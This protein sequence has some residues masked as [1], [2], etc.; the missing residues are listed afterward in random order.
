MKTK[1]KG[2]AGIVALVAVIVAIIV[3]GGYFLKSKTWVSDDQFVFTP[4]ATT[5]PASTSSNQDLTAE[6]I[7]NSN[8]FASEEGFAV[9]QPEVTLTGIDFVGFE[10]DEVSKIIHAKERA[11]GKE[12]DIVFSPSIKIF[13]SAGGSSVPQYHDY[14]F[15]VDWYGRSKTGADRMPPGGFKIK[16]SHTLPPL[17]FDASEI[18]WIIG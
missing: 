18:S 2:F 8:G 15:L 4:P 7:L 13:G 10:T 12:F 9:P 11:T 1:Q 14:Q 6:K 17:T 3:G 5:T 16:G